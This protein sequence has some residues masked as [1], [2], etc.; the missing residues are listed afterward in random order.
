LKALVLWQVWSYDNEITAL[1]FPTSFFR[2]YST[3]YVQLIL[4]RVMYEYWRVPTPGDSPHHPDC[5]GLQAFCYGSIGAPFY[6]MEMLT[7]TSVLTAFGLVSTVLVIGWVHIAIESLLAIQ[8]NTSVTAG[9]YVADI[10]SN[11]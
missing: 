8:S 3:H 1:G 5:F 4:L 2:H 10:A 7:G 11:T 6:A 9:L